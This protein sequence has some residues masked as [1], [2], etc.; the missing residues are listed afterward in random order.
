M[1]KSIDYSNDVISAAEKTQALRKRIEIAAGD[2]LSLL[3]ATSDAAAIAMYSVGAIVNAL[4]EGESITDLIEQNEFIKITF[5]FFQKVES[6][7]LELPCQT[8]SLAKSS[9]DINANAAVVSHEL[10]NQ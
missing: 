9:N 10:K 5:Q 8:K 7:E 2:T 1:D 6:N 4:N 3:S